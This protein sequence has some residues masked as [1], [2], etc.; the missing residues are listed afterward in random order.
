MALL[1]G[2]AFCV[3]T[4]NSTSTGLKN[5]GVPIRVSTSAAFWRI[6][7]DSIYFAEKRIHAGRQVFLEN[8]FAGD[9]PAWRE[10]E[11]FF[12]ASAMLLRLDRLLKRP[13][14]KWEDKV[15]AYLEQCEQ[16]VHNAEGVSSGERQRLGK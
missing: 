4:K 13:Q 2:I 5:A 3:A 7:G 9:L 10:D 11:P 12:V 6:Y 8:Y 15:D 14:E 16:I 1:A